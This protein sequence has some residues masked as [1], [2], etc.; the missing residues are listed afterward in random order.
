MISVMRPDVILR[1]AGLGGIHARSGGAM[2]MRAAGRL[3]S[4]SRI[5]EF[6]VFAVLGLVL[7]PFGIR[8]LVKS[9]RF[10]FF[11]RL[12]RRVETDEPVVALT[13]DDG[14]CPSSSS[15][16]LAALRARGVRA[17]F[18]VIGREAARSEPILRAMVDDG[19]ELG[20][21]S[22][23][24][25]RMVLT[26]PAAVRDEIDRTDAL[27]HATGQPG[28]IHF[29]PPCCAKL[30]ALPH[31]LARTGRTT[32][33]WDVEP[34][35]TPDSSMRPVEH[36]VRDAIEQTRAG[37]IILLHAAGARNANTRAALPRILDALI[38]RGFAFVTVS[39]LIAR[40]AARG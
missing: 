23:S 34:D 32:V 35:T 20:N 30:L 21:H 29:R 26:S 40:G 17:T 3:A 37:S 19:H 12:V 33:L 22:Y 14:P 39:E 7:T 27:I 15:E 1:G 38:A 31:H 11:G 28:A 16:L 4:N 18:F 13:F 25:R 36:I 9:R 5:V 10:Q 6:L 24:H 8:R 2:A